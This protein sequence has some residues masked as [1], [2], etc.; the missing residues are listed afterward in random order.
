LL[1]AATSDAAAAIVASLHTGLY[2]LMFGAKKE[3]WAE[4][5]QRGLYSDSAYKRTDIVVIK[6]MS[7]QSR[8]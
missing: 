8:K 1:V 2:K 4:S 7:L 3:S 5:C 6:V